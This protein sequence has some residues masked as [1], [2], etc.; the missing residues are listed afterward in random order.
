M[1]RLTSR[2]RKYNFIF[3]ILAVAI[4]V[5]VTVYTVAMHSQIEDYAQ[6]AVERNADGIS[7][8]VSSY[9]DSAFSTYITAG[10]PDN[11]R[12]YY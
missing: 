7:K 2:I 12:Q 8:V 4:T 9:I 6:Y 3:C 1:N 5:V 11:V 10:I